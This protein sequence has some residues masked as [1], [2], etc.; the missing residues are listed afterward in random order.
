MAKRARAKMHLWSYTI[1]DG[2]I[3]GPASEADFIEA[4]KSGQVQ[5]TTRVHSDTRTNGKWVSD[6]EEL[7]A[8]SG[9]PLE[10]LIESGFEH[11]LADEESLRAM[12]RGCDRLAN[13]QDKR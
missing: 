10:N 3:M 6:S 4:I 2:Q 8:N 5:R 7:L 9:L 13:L 12:L 1:D 11:R